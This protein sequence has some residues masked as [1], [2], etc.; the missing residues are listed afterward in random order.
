MKMMNKFQ[1]NSRLVFL[2][3]ICLAMICISGCS[4]FLDVNQ[5]PNNPESATPNLLLPTAQVALGATVGSSFQVYGSILSQYWTQSPSASQ[6][7]TIEQYA[8]S[9]AG[10]NYPWVYLYRDALINLQL[11]IDNSNEHQQQY[12]AIAYILKAYGLQLT[13]DAF[14]DVPNSTALKGAGSP[15][16]DKQELIYDSIFTYINK[17]RAMLDNSSPEKPGSEDVVF[18]GNMDNWIKF[19]NTLALRA[20]MRLSEVDAEKAEKG[21]AALYSSKA[22]FLDVDAKINYST[23][24]GNQNPLYINMVGLGKAQNLVAS[25]TVI[26]RFILNK[27]PRRFVLYNLLA[28]TKEI[29]A[30]AQGDYDANGEKKVSPPSALVGANAQDDASALA[31][32]RLISASESYFLQ[33]EAVAR[34]WGSGT[35]SAKNLFDKGIEASFAADGLADSAKAYIATAPDAQFPSSSDA[36]IKSIITQKYYAMCGSQGFEAW[37]EWRRTGFPDF[38][39]KS[40]AAGKLPF[41]LRFL[42]PNSEVTSNLNYPGTVPQTTAVWWDK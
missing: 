5:N 22:E 4:K 39:V 35:L 15:T 25:S 34:G 42:Y 10:F 13:T 36:Q 12:A 17:G 38:F 32:V 11:I 18:Q 8:F 9:N 6:Y 16:Y 26:N 28:G 14:G 40:I 33:A 24:G 30:I 23:T 20:Y 31:P 29:T 27:D 37:T 21:I 3:M 1:K 7:K 19:A 41:P 2:G